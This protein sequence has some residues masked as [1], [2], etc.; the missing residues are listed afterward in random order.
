MRRRDFITLLG[1]AAAAWPLTVRAQKGDT[2]RRIGVLMAF[3]DTDIEGQAR[4]GALREELATLGWSNGKNLL[5]DTR[6]GA[7]SPD[8]LR[9]YAAELVRQKPDVIVVSGTTPLMAL[10]QETTTVPIIF[11]NVADPVADGLVES[12]AHPGGN[13]TGITNYEYAITGKWVEAL[14]EAAPQVTRILIIYYPENAAVPGQLHALET[15]ASSSAVQLTKAGVHSSA[16]IEQA[17]VAFAREPNG[18]LI[19]LPD[20]NIGM[21][22]KRIISLAEQH[23]LPTLYPLRYFVI[24][25]GLMSYGV[26]PQDLFR[27]AASYVDR[28]LKGEKPGDLPVQAPT[29]FELVIN[30]KAAKAIGLT[31]PPT[32]LA[33]ADEVIE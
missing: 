16:E 9:S 28:I 32:L 5:F 21:H 12:L 11:A 30:L 10:R 4:L 31:V 18:G 2:V 25:G 6:W 29:K 13:I 26:N 23:R 22:R 3:A 20:A 33:R 15:V 24:D 27:R 1:G 8:R 14:K 19:I 17:V 7:G